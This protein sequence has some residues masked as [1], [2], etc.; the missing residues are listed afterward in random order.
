MVL[1]HEIEMYLLTLNSLWLKTLFGN[2]TQ[3]SRREKNNKFVCFK[4]ICVSWFSTTSHHHLLYFICIIWIYF[5]N[6]F[7]N[8]HCFTTIIIAFNSI[9]IHF[10]LSNILI[11][12][13]FLS[14]LLFSRCTLI[15]SLFCQLSNT[16]NCTN[17][18]ERWYSNKVW[19]IDSAFIHCLACT[20]HTIW[21]AWLYYSFI[22]ISD[23][24]MRIYLALGCQTQCWDLWNI[25]YTTMDFSLL[26]FDETV[27]VIQFIKVQLQGSGALHKCLLLYLLQTSGWLN[28]PYQRCLLSST[29]A[30]M[31]YSAFG[32]T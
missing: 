5:M 8:S 12:K 1:Q 4:L 3:E 25:F 32:S 24:D 9:L 11:D 14:F 7:C 18:Y 23:W 19:L 17:L 22:L 15:Y 6:L 13:L 28:A 21:I 26:N 30:Q 29:T 10:F 16:L 2:K 27:D 31:S 20:L